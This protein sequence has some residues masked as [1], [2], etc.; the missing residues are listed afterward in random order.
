MVYSLCYIVPLIVLSLAW[1]KYKSE[2]TK[3]E[4]CV[5]TIACVMVTLL[6]VSGT[7]A[8]YRG[9]VGYDTEIWNGSV[10]S[11]SSE[12]VS[13]EHEYVCGETC[14]GSGKN[15]SCSP[16]YCDE[17]SYDV[18]WIVNT[19]IGNYVID[20]VDRRGLDTPPRFDAVR[21]GEPVSSENGYMNYLLLR[22]DSLFA[23]QQSL[24]RVYNDKIPEYPVVYDYYRFNRVFNS[25]SD[26]STG[27]NEY[28]SSELRTDGPVHQANFILFITYL[29][30]EYA[31]AVIAK[32]RGA[33]KNDIIVFL[34]LNSSTNTVQWAYANTFG[35]GVGNELLQTKVL[36]TAIS[37][38][39]DLSLLQKVYK[40]SMQSYH[41][42]SME[43]F[44]YLLGGIQYPWYLYL[45]VFI[46]ST[47]ASIGIVILLYKHDLYSTLF[48]RNKR[49]NQY[50]YNRYRR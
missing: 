48:N 44:A 4:Y 39:M 50:Q 5:G 34:G 32:W 45:L 22:S 42:Y 27:Y 30:D 16:K 26:D 37:E 35:N 20:R 43:K 29:P 40:V 15:R 36:S 21:I 18:D 24:V 47:A 10:I 31:H 7:E 23:A 6:L 19:S 11:K 1:V 8:I 2:I 41:R 25:T 9:G 17:H 46:F 38:K 13:C 49:Y 14:T 33:K 28:I 3:F 12:E